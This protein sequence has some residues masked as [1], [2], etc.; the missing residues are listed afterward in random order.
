MKKINEL[1]FNNIPTI[2]TSLAFGIVWIINEYAIYNAK[3]IEI[4]NFIERNSNHLLQIDK[5]LDNIDKKLIIYDYQYNYI[6][7]E[8][9]RVEQQVMEALNNG[10][11]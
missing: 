5:E 8:L 10:N 9:K 3:Q 11:K 2:L 4:K 7:N 1:F 6:N